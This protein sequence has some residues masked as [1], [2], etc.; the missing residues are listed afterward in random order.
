MIDVLPERQGALSKGQ[1]LNKLIWFKEIFLMVLQGPGVFSQRLQSSMFAPQMWRFFF[2]PHLALSLYSSLISLLLWLFSYLH[3][4]PEINYI[5]LTFHAACCHFAICRPACPVQCGAFK[6][7]LW[8]SEKR[9]SPFLLL[10]APIQAFLLPFKWAV[11]EVSLIRLSQLTLVCAVCFPPKGV[12]TSP[13]LFSF[14]LLFA[15][16]NQASTQGKKKTLSAVVPMDSFIHHGPPNDI[17]YLEWVTRPLYMGK[18]FKV[19]QWRIWTFP[20]V[21]VWVPE[22]R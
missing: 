4:N 12:L 18:V 8:L 20:L 14:I 16:F 5:C 2:P 10:L 9:E 7:P 13:M 15:L 21:S 22:I 6:E 11:D 19:V 17:G 3:K 1:N